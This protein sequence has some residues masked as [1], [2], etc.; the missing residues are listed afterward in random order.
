LQI[1]KSEKAWTFAYELRTT[2]KGVMNA[3]G[4]L[5]LLETLEFF[6]SSFRLDLKA[7]QATLSH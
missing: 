5:P 1:K 3:I 2:Y 4:K 7:I 6:N